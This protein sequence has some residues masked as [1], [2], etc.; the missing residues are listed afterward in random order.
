[1]IMAITDTLTAIKSYFFAWHE[2][3]YDQIHKE[4]ID[5]VSEN[6]NDDD[7]IVTNKGIREYIQSEITLIKNIIGSNVLNA[8]KGKGTLVDIVNELTALQSKNISTD[9]WMQYRQRTATFSYS[10]TDRGGTITVRKK[11]KMCIC[12]IRGCKIPKGL[13][14]NTEYVLAALPT[15]RDGS[16]SD[17][18]TLDTSSDISPFWKTNSTYIGSSSYDEVK[19]INV[20]NFD[21][22]N[23][24]SSYY[25][26]TIGGNQLSKSEATSSYPRG[27]ITFKPLDNDHERTIYATVVYWTSRYPTQTDVQKVNR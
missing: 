19:W 4:A 18:V 12:N 22:Y 9:Q 20:R 14:T 27:V 23:P 24:T 13:N 7:K 1:M 11:K 10:Y 15:N 8:F 26:K 21:S 25:V 5:Q 16:E 3:Y 17:Y 6:P 2:N